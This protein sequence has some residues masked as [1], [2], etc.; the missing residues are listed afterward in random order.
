[1]AMK[2]AYLVLYNVASMLGWSYVL[3]STITSFLRGDSPAELWE[4]I[5]SVLTWV[6]TAA[7]LEILHSMV[8]L[9]RSPVMTTAMQVASRLFIVWVVTVPSQVAQGHWSLYSLLASWS[10][11]EVPRYMFYTVNVIVGSPDK[12][13]APLFF[14]RYS[15]FMVLYP[16]GIFSEMMQMW[17]SYTTLTPVME[18]LVMSTFVLYFPIGPFMVLNMW[19]TRKRSYKKRNLLKKGPRP[20]NGLVW[21]VTKQGTSERSTTAT[22]K[23]IISSSLAA[24][25]NKEA[26]GKAIGTKNWRFGY[27]KHIVNQVRLSCESPVAAIESARAGLT[28]A[29][30]RFEFV[31]D[32]ESM[33]LHKA[34]T[35][36]TGGF[37]T[38]VMVGEGVLPKKPILRVPYG[39]T[40][41]QPYYKF[42][43]VDRVL[44]NDALIAQLHAWVKR[45]TIEKSCGD[46]IVDV[47]KN[48]H[49]YLDLSN[50]YFVLLGATSAMGPLETLL[51]LG[52]N[53][54]AI[55]INLP[56][57]WKKLLLKAKQ[58]CGR[59]IFP[60]S[61]T[62]SPSSDMTIDELS[63]LAGS[64]LLTQTPEIAN[65]IV[66]TCKGKQVTIGNYTYLDGA[67]HV[68]LSLACDAIIERLCTANEGVSIA[69]LQTPTDCHVISEE[70]W[71]AAKENLKKAPLWQKLFGSLSSSFMIPNVEPPVKTSTGDTIYIVNGLVVQQGPNYA[72]A[73]RIQH[74]RAVIARDAGHA[75]S[76]NVAPST[77][78]KSVVSASLFAAAYGGWHKFTPLE[79]MYQE[80]SNAVMCALLLHDIHSK[81]SAANPNVMLRNPMELF[82]YAAFHGGIDRC[83]FTL[84][85]L[86]PAMVLI[87][88]YN[89][90]GVY[91]VPTVAS[92]VAWG[93]WLLL[94]R[95]G[96]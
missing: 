20:V 93:Q 81:T 21:P 83:A 91:V 33:P 31:R 60:M 52:A 36:I 95:V 58:S 57:V 19:M 78:T 94:G 64:N 7:A 92:V 74:W 47:V 53:I 5:G 61:G 90:Y 65:W 76:T 15:L 85:S 56:H 87:Y 3:Y 49:H 46:A 79:V 55:D 59:V 63:N 84:P 62:Q 9:V 13:P 25:E 4:T 29:H 34:M 42:K 37:A 16:S 70:A 67:L 71:R 68:Q 40:A 82:S 24:F 27:M 35:T 41:G 17:V 43:K 8:G 2:K 11:V 12:I 54:I 73:K 88:F 50:H 45:G 69:F 66:E 14:L 75:V 28:D 96:F 86:A 6:Q 51:S 10:L 89:Q 26:H 48:Q 18:R 1:M 22:N 39:G 30:S 32:G 23:A 38:G 44:E 72:L 77:A 80:T